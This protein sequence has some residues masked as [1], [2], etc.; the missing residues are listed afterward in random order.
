VYLLLRRA[1]CLLSQ[2]RRCLKLRQW[3]RR[4]RPLASIL[5]RWDM[6]YSLSLSLLI[7]PWFSQ[8]SYVI[9][10]FFI[11]F[12][13]VI[14]CGLIRC[15]HYRRRCKIR[16]PCCDEVFYCR[17]CHNESTVCQFSR[18]SY[19]LSENLATTLFWY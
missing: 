8:T 7:S 15:K 6:G 16:A 17:H 13:E 1:H 10:F 14:S 4:K 19:F 5:A 18:F 2:L 9:Y 11:N 3:R 12:K